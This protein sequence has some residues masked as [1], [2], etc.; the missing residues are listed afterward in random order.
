VYRST[1]RPVCHP[2]SACAESDPD[3]A[4]VAV[5]S[6][7]VNLADDVAFRVR[8]A[9]EAECLPM[10]RLRPRASAISASP[11]VQGGTPVFTGTRVPVA[12]LFDYLEEGESLESFLQQ[13]PSVNR[14]QIL[15]VLEA[16]KA[17]IARTT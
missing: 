16:A 12:I 3:L 1:I 11:D 13:H 17:G 14:D 4:L 15:E 5:E 6:A 8:S 7:L 2:R 9:R 10:D